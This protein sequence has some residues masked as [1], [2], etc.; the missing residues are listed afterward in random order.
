METAHGSY[1]FWVRG[2]YASSAQFLKEKCDCNLSNFAVSSWRARGKP[3]HRLVLS[4]V[5]FWNDTVHVFFLL[6]Q[7]LNFFLQLLNVEIACPK[8]DN[9]YEKVLNSDW[10]QQEERKNRVRILWR[11]IALLCTVNSKVRCFGHSPVQ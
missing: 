8:Y 9:A 6:K 1:K 3:R 11:I 10:V 7:I 4:R 5:K 2:M